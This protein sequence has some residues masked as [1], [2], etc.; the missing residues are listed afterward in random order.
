MKKI[1]IILF[2]MVSL[3]GISQVG[4]GLP[5][6][7]N[8]VVTADRSTTYTWN[9]GS[10]FDFEFEITGRYEYDEIKLS[11]YYESVNSQNLISLSRWNREGD[12]YLDF[13]TMTKKEWWT[14]ISYAWQNKSFTIPGNRFILVVSVPSKNYYKELYY[15]APQSLSN[16]HVI[17]YRGQTK[18][19]AT[20][21][22]CNND[23]EASV[24]VNIQNASLTVG[25]IYK[26]D[27]GTG[28]GY[29]WYEVTSRQSGASNSAD[30]T[31]PS[32]NTSSGYYPDCSTSGGSDEPDLKFNLNGS[33]VYSD[34]NS[35]DISATHRLDFTNSMLTFN[36]LI[37]N[38]GDA[39]SNATEIEFY[40]SG[41]S[42]FDPNDD[43]PINKVLSI[44]A[45]SAGNSDG[46]FSKTLFVNDFE[47]GLS[48]YW[49]VIAKIKADD[50]NNSNNT[51]AVRVYFNPSRSSIK[52]N[53][54]TIQ[55]EYTTKKVLQ[56]YNLSGVRVTKDE[57]SSQDEENAIIQNLEHGI[58]I[59]KSGENTYKIKK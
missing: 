29:R 48:G 10:R 19:A 9:S 45:I 23:Q 41:N 17:K 49:Y 51:V 36:F 59:I 14:T 44:P 37:D 3:S 4:L 53:K 21:S 22:K 27:R 43:A 26:I 34:A 57:I 1:T 15:E 24:G 7:Q 35:F 58:Y 13:P 5:D 16:Y 56:I 30:T 38:I 39:Q 42:I 32:S 8:F 2:L 47:S 52:F 20:D 11:V 33:S 18:S 12:E 28:I 55:R 31:I 46:H 40:R 50:S 54:N 6:V 25:K